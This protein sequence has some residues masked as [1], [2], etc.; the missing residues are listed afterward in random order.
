M[1][2]RP[3]MFARYRRLRAQREPQLIFASTSRSTRRRSH[4]AAISKLARDGKFDA[5]K[6]AKAIAEM[7]LDPERIDPAVA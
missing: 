3:A 7:G 1:A 6:A 5:K 2:A 4:A